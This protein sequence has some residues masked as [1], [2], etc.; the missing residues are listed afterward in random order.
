MF[1]FVLFKANAVLYF[2]SWK[3]TLGEEQTAGW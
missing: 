3:V 2:P 1:S